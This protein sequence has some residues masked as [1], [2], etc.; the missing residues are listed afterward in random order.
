M[1]LPNEFL[2]L[3]ADILHITEQIAIDLSL[4]YEYIATNQ[5]N[6]I[7][8]QEKL[9]QKV[10]WAANQHD[11]LQTNFDNLLEYLQQQADIGETNEKLRIAAMMELSHIKAIN[12]DVL[13]WRE[14]ANYY[15]SVNRIL[16]KQLQNERCNANQSQM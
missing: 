12:K 4:Q 7:T 9:L 5:P 2:N 16:F 6:N 1:T 13:H 11:K 15:Q 8:R 3:V 14:K 10:E